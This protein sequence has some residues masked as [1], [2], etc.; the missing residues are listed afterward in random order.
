[1]EPRCSYL[2]FALNLLLQPFIAPMWK[3]WWTSPIATG[4]GHRQKKSIR[5]PQLKRLH[6]HQRRPEK[7]WSKG[8][9]Q[10]SFKSVTDSGKDFKLSS[11]GFK[12]GKGLSCDTK[13]GSVA[14]PK[15]TWICQLRHQIWISC[16][17]EPKKTGEFD[18][19]FRNLRGGM[20]G[21]GEEAEGGRMVGLGLRGWRPLRKLR[22][23]TAPGG[24]RRDWQFNGNLR[25][26]GMGGLG[27]R[28]G[29]IGG[30]QGGI[31]GK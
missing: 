7:V 8:F 28:H 1:M 9:Q 21:L 6:V 26:G 4:H 31:R 16:D 13:S 22:G 11:E 29:G 18:W 12:S 23:R 2:N 24:I 3:F 30:G 10:N 20:G 15:P 27:G 19:Q 14:T 25:E 17:T 5:T